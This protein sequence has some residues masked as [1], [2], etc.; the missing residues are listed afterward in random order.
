MVIIYTSKIKIIG[1]GTRG[2]EPPLNLR[3][4]HRNLIFAIENNFSLAKVPP[5]TFS[6]FL[7]QWSKLQS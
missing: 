5:L 2:Q 4:L 3:P 7:R 1:G 6:S